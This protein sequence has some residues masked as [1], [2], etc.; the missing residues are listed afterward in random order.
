MKQSWKIPKLSVKVLGPHALKIAR[1]DID[2][3]LFQRGCILPTRHCCRQ[4]W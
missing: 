2:A 1:Y 3:D 4:R